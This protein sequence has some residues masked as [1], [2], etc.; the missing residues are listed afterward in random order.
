MEKVNK[1][2]HVVGALRSTVESHKNSAENKVAQNKTGSQNP[3]NPIGTNSTE[4]L[5]AVLKKRLRAVDDKSK[6]YDEQVAQVY[7]A[8]TLSHEF[9]DNIIND[10]AFSEMVDDIREQIDSK[11]EI[12]DKLHSTIKSLL[13]D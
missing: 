6:D 9:G 3:L 10:I 13:A 11:P 4:T 5:K 7:I 1:I 2:N 8:A 12:K